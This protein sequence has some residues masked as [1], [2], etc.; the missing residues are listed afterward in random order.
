MMQ[1]LSLDRTGF[2]VSCCSIAFREKPMDEALESIKAAGFCG[3]EIWFP[4][5]EKMSEGELRELASLCSKSGIR[6]PVIA[7]YFSFTRGPEAARQSLS[8]GTKAIQA[9]AILGCK[10]VRTFVDVG[11]DGLP[12]RLADK[13][14]W[15]AACRGLRELCSMDPGIEFVLEAHDHT[16]ADTYPSI[17]HLFERVNASNLKL[18][19]QMVSD[20]LE[21]GYMKCLRELF[22]LVGHLHLQQVAPGGVHTYVEEPGRVD[23]R[24]LIAFLRR[25]DYGG[26]ASLEYCWS[27]VDAGRC[28]SGAA[29]LADCFDSVF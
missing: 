20:F 1:K 16:L 11:R 2:L 14:N 4:H 25:Q 23:F 15:D 7:P 3:V 13:G 19:F 6:I 26:T 12:S 10:K 21:R 18:N 28:D 8:T 9:A 29:Y 17:I 22:P 24:E 27:P 5:I